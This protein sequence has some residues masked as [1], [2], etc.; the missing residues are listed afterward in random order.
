MNNEKDYR[1][2]A[3][4]IQDSAHI[5]NTQK[6]NSMVGDQIVLSF[7]SQNGTVIFNSHNCY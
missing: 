7:L 2:S 6:K 3:S 1:N 4:K 5:E